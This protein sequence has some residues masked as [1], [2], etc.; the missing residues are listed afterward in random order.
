MNPSHLEWA[1]FQQELVASFQGGEAL[2]LNL[3]FAIYYINKVRNLIGLFRHHT[4][5]T[6]Q[7]CTLT[8]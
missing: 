5:T 6:L 2:E 1:W 4:V 3:Q 8:V 7:H